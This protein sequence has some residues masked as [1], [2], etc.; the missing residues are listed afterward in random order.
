MENNKK[1]DIVAMKRILAAGKF[2][3]FFGV[4]SLVMAAL[5]VPGMVNNIIENAEAFELAMKGG[6]FLTNA[7]L[8][9]LSFFFARKI[10]KERIEKEFQNQQ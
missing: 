6:F 2:N 7:G 1:I 9:W 5:C 8:S 10:R 3:R 4:L